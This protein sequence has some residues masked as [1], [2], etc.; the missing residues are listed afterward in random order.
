MLA[1]R[2]PTPPAC[3][4]LV[5]STVFLLYCLFTS[6][7]LS[8]TKFY[9]PMATRNQQ[10]LIDSD[11][12]IYGLT[13][14]QSQQIFEIYRQ[15]AEDERAA[16]A[17]EH[18][19][20]LECMKK[21]SN[22]RIAAAAAV[23]T[24]PGPAAAQWSLGNDDDIIGEIPKEVQ[25]L[26]IR[27]AGL[28]QVEIVR[29]FHNK[30]KPINLYRLRHM[31]GQ[32]YESY[33]DQERIGIQDGMLK[34]RKTS[35]SYEDYGK[36]FD[37]VWSESFLNYIAIMV[38]LFAPITAELKAALITYYDNILQLAQVYEWQEA[39]LPLAIEVHTY[40][41]SLQPSDPTKWVIPP[42]VQGR[43]CNPGTLIGSTT[44][45]SQ[46]KQ[47]LSRSSPSRR[48]F[49]QPGGPSNNPTVICGIFNKASCSHE[50]CKRAH[51]CKGCGSRE[52]GLVNCLV[53]RM[54]GE[55]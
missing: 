53:K 42:E 41:S 13:A 21:E 24:A 9:S 28:P 3:Q 44:S 6:P 37:K 32:R 25:S 15:K 52:H 46:T 23:R 12:S 19:F 48:V 35:G 18:A 1:S 22:A 5:A 26:N 33:Y 54:G 38:S 55:A 8:T 27:F 34:L 16:V 30:F 39:V 17:R 20:K 36:S 2:Y 29:I 43:L 11:H 7:R 47:K 14:E 51:K 4:L 40:I 31:R 49:K 10:T 50:N 45:Q